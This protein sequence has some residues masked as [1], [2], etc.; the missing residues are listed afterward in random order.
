MPAAVA[1]DRPVPMRGTAAMVA[2]VRPL[3]AKSGLMPGTTR[4]K[5]AK[6]AAT[7]GEWWGYS[8]ALEVN[9]L[10]YLAFK[11]KSLIDLWGG[12][13]GHGTGTY[14]EGGG[15]GG[16][17]EVGTLKIVSSTIKSAGKKESTSSLLQNGFGAGG[18]AG[19]LGENGAGGTNGYVKI[20]Y[21][22]QV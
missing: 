15:D 13:G 22:G 14:A 16:K 18:K 17:L 12:R 3:W 4:S 2:A 9:G 5:S 19:D 21:L 20:V 10:T 11:G 8:S 7:R 6:A 1:A